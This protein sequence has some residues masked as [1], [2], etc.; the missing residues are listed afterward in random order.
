MFGR[1]AHVRILLFL[2]LATSRAEA[3][4]L[5][6]SEAAIAGVSERFEIRL[7][8][9]RLARLAGVAPSRGARRE[10]ES[11]EGAPVRVAIL[12]P[13]PDR[14]GR[15]LVD[16]TLTDQSSA[17]ITLLS[18]GLARVRPEFETKD[19]ESERIE[20]EG[21]ARAAREGVWAPPG[22]ILDA[23]DAVALR[24]GDGRFVLVEGT[25]RRVGVRRS[26]VYLD[27][28]RRGGFTAV[29]PRKAEAAFQRRGFDLERL[30]GRRIRV[31]GVLENRFGPRIEVADPSMIEPGEG[32]QETKPG[33]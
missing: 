32:A 28:D 10:I 30:A 29:V 33:G 15:W 21:A 6:S 16:L 26:R 9:G 3:C 7:A 1:A 20:A 18:L 23:L 8:D 22:A 4:G 2:I 27:F 17:A 31:R 25:V 24:E 14:W 13:R 12:S 5:A 11:W 19:C